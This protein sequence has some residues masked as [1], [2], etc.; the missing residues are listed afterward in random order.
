VC[1]P[2]VVVVVDAG[3]RRLKRKSCHKCVTLKKHIRRNEKTEEDEKTRKYV[4]N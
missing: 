2:P 4:H 1:E 3:Q